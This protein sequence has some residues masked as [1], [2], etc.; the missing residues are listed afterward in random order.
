MQARAL[1]R[2]FMVRLHSKSASFYWSLSSF[3]IHGAGNLDLKAR[4]PPCELLRLAKGLGCEVNGSRIALT[5]IDPY[6]R[7]LVYAA[8][9]P[10][11]LNLAKAVELMQLVEGM[12]GWDAHYW[13]SRFREIW[14][15]HNCYRSLLKA[16]KAFKLFFGLE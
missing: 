14:W 8:V 9:R 12:S 15:E 1:Q 16:V 7:L 6:N 11:L 5:D 2:Q 13:A 3:S 4:V 10:T